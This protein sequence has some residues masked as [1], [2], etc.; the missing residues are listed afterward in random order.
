MDERRQELNG[1]MDKEVILLYFKCGKVP[2][3]G[4]ANRGRKLIV[5]ALME[6]KQSG[7]QKKKQTFFRGFH[8]SSSK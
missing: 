2:H 5:L 4:K 8:T 7:T 1:N 6:Q 3:K